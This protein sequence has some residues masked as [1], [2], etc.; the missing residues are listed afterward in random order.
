V[1]AP[2]FLLRPGDLDAAA[3]GGTLLLDGAE[4]RHA[5]L[6]RRIGAGERVDVAD[7][8][9]VVV[10]C[11]V[12]HVTVTDQ[13]A[14]G[15]QL[16]VLEVARTPEP[17]PR[18]VLVQALAKGG[19]DDQALE[20]AT[21]LGVDEVVPW[22]AARSVVVWRGARADK[23]HASWVATVR[24]AAK[25]SR[26]PRVPE[27]APLVAG[28]SLAER[29]TRSALAVVLHEEAAVP[30]ASLTLPDQGEVLLIVGPEG[31]IAPDELAALTA[32]G[33]VAARLGQH[34]LRSSTAG[35]AALAVLSAAG[36]WR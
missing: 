31:G 3:A 23:A 33:A 28:G 21:E 25:Q 4:G 30:L 9:G 17:S 27:V 15:L 13:R 26:R 12:H 16:D 22:Q 18:I 1:T 32:A 2:L 5:A 10:R 7:G 6:V 35:P 8:A 11:Q 34:V 29:V 24:A 36:R 19:R 20:A 14:T